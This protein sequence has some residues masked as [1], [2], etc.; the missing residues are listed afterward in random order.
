[1]GIFRF[2]NFRFIGAIAQFSAVLV[3]NLGGCESMSNHSL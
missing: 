1:M 2:Q 3:V